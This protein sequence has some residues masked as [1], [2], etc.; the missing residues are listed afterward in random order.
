MK[1]ELRK[2]LIQCQFCYKSKGSGV[3]LQKCAGCKIDLYCS[4]ECQK[5]AWKTHK[6]KCLLNQ[7]AKSD[8]PVEHVDTLKMLR[9]FTSKHRPSIAQAS[10]MA[11]DVFADPARAE[12]DLLM[13]RLRPRPDSS[14]LETSFVV[15]SINIVPIDTFP[16]AQE[17][18]TQ[19]KQASD[20]N[21]RTGMAGAIFVLLMDIESKAANVTAVGFPRKMEGVPPSLG[22]STCWEDWLTARL[23]S[24]RAFL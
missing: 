19:L 5:S 8:L 10:V 6:P 20:D 12:R 17:L 13:I 9:G 11:L 3:T 4:K 21:K 7:R 23:D 24:G 1:G 14:R 22:S 2:E 18:Y 15:T 16:T